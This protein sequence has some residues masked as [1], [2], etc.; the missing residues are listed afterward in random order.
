MSNKRIDPSMHPA[1]L[2]KVFAY[3]GLLPLVLAVILALYQKLNWSVYT[4]IEMSF[5]RINSYIYAHSYGA[6][7]LTLFAGIQIGTIMSRETHAWYVVFNFALLGFGW[8]SY[9]SFADAQGLALL[10]CC[11]LAAMIIDINAKQHAIVP[12]WYGHLKLKINAGVTTLLFILLMIN[13]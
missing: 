1:K 10:L 9:Q 7:L 2:I 13:R 12:V 11:W 5:A 6:L 8:I 3:L 4:G